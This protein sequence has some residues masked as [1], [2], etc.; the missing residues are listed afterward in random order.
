[1]QAREWAPGDV[2]ADK[3]R[4]ETELGRGGMGTVFR[5]EHLVLRSPVAV[6]LIVPRAADSSEIRTRFVREAQAAA[7]LRSP[8]VVSILDYGVHGETPFIVMELLEGESLARRMQRVGVLSPMETARIL[9]HVARAV[10]KAHDSGIV[11]RDLKP[12]NVFLVHNVDEE[13]AKVL[14]FGIAKTFIGHEAVGAGT[15]TG[16]V[17]GTPY[18]MSPE[19]ARGT[20][21]VDHRTDTWAL[22]VIVFQCLTGR[23]PF[24]GTVLADLLMK[25]C[26]EPIPPPSSFAPVPGG[27]DEWFRKAT[28]R[29]PDRRFQSAIEMAEAFRQIAG[30]P[31]VSMAPSAS[32]AAPTQA[33]IPQSLQL[34]TSVPAPERKSAVP[35]IAIALGALLAIAAIAGI[36]ILLV[37]RSRS[38]PSETASATPSA[39][40]APT[41]TA[42]S[43]ASAGPSASS[44]PSKVG[45]KVSTTSG[46]KAPAGTQDDVA[47]A[48]SD[49]KNAQTEAAKARTEADKARKEAE[50]ARKALEGI[51]K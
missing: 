23:L 44:A 49:A 47:K 25:I 6:K 41:E 26:A 1:M 7:A 51:G 43:V 32:Y 40:A 4:L 17:L 36:V 3:Y 28:D 46:G 38:E 45:T 24:E 22:G 31:S 16:A 27:F 33:I 29:D 42:T 13:I 11:H 35:A 8:H 48:Q 30:A 14:D 12:D 5:A 37:M 10:Q 21:A 18:Y 15:Q 39:S 9:V 19:Q 50:A 20:R 34:S 2:L